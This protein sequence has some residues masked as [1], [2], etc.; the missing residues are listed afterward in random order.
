MNATDRR[1][2]NNSICDA[3]VRT[4]YPRAPGPPCRANRGNI[5]A[6]PQGFRMAEV[7]EYRCFIGNLSW[8]TTDESLRDAFGKFG[9]VTE[10]KYCVATASSIL[11]DTKLHT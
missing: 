4:C 6:P 2:S 5:S 11:N 3:G 1:D 10:A 9:K 7:E 8:S